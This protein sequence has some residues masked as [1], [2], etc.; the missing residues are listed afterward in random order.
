MYNLTKS[1]EDAN[2]YLSTN[3]DNDKYINYKLNLMY[4]STERTDYEIVFFL[5]R[6]KNKWVL[7]QPTDSDLEKI[8]GIFQQDN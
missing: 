4:N 2:N 1:I 6:T 7:E 5:N 3:F 8:H